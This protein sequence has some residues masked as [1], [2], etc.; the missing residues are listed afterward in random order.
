MSE[1]WVLCAGTLPQVGFRD[2]VDAAAEAGFAAI[3]LFPEHYLDAVGREGLDPSAIHRLLQGA[4]LVVHQLDPLLDWYSNDATGSELGLYDAAEVT[5]ATSLNV[6]P[7]F[8]PTEDLSFLIDRLGA[9]GDRAAVRG[10]SIDLEF[11]PWSPIPDLGTATAI[12]EAC[13]LPNVGVMLDSWHFF[14]SGGRVSEL[15]PDVI[16]RITGVQLNDAPVVPAQRG[17]RGR[18]DTNRALLGWARNGW[19]TLGA[20][21]LLRLTRNAAQSADPDLIGETLTQRLLPGDGEQPVAELVAALKDGGCGAA[22]GVEV[23]NSQLHRL[24]AREVARRAMGGC[25]R[26]AARLD[27]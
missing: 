15:T 21:D 14:R 22:M 17:I 19:R 10:L 7:A 18:W 6:V 23:F 13:E 24:P 4:G 12:V 26:V 2:R 27:I 1:S 5:G 25:L 20:R 16:G 8:A 11:L 3:T 9:L